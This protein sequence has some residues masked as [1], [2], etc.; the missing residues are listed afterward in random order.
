MYNLLD[1]SQNVQYFGQR[2]QRV[3]DEES[4]DERHWVDESDQITDRITLPKRKTTKMKA[5]SKSLKK[6]AP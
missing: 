5:S 6:T 3:I 4:D 2:I 1:K